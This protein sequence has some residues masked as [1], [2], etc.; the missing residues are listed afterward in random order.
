MKLN[1]PLILR[2][3]CVSWF[4]I[5]TI[6]IFLFLPSLLYVFR[7]SKSINILVWADLFSSQMITQ[8]EQETGIK[9]YVSY[10]TSNEE[11]FVKLKS[12]GWLV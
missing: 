7:P 8:F 1:V 2:R 9:V 6:F 10:F 12:T 3:L 11:L 5:G 4:W